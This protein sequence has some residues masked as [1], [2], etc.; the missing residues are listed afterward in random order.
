MHRQVGV[1]RPVAD[2]LVHRGLMI[3]HLIMPND[4]AGTR[5]VI[6]W[7]ATNLPADTRLTLMSQY[8]PMADASD[9]SGISRRVTRAEYAD[10]VRW[11]REVGLTNLDIQPG[12]L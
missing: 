9:H 11:A 4:T 12:P 1:A 2:G 7:I 6:N 5:A 8:Q 10:A 3:R